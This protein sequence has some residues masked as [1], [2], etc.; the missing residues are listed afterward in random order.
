MLPPPPYETLITRHFGLANEV[1]VY[2]ETSESDISAIIKHRPCAWTILTTS[3]HMHH[4]Y[5]EATGIW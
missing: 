2:V 4:Y 5:Y 1:H 3:Y